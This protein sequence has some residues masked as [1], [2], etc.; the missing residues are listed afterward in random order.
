MLPLCI[1][2]RDTGG[3]SAL[4]LVNSKDGIT[5]SLSQDE[6][7]IIKAL[8]SGPKPIRYFSKEKNSISSLLE[9]NL[10]EEV[11]KEIKLKAEVLEIDPSLV[12]RKQYQPIFEVASGLIAAL[13]FFLRKTYEGALPKEKKEQCNL[14]RSLLVEHTLWQLRHQESLY[15]WEE[16][17]ITPNL[18]K[19]AP[20]VNK[21]MDMLLQFEDPS[22]VVGEWKKTGIPSLRES[23]FSLYKK[24]IGEQQK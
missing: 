5:E 18:G 17:Y 1:V 13:T 10:I 6:A 20:V 24:T 14:I 16:K 4:Y 8:F 7:K 19:I 9:S 3:V 12:F 11:D 2:F 23:E 21:W 22:K 15:D